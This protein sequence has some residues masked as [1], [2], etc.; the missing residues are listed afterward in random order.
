MTSNHIRFRTIRFFMQNSFRTAS[1][2]A[3]TVSTIHFARGNAHFYFLTP[4][5]T[6]QRN[7]KVHPILR[8]VLV[9]ALWRPSS[10]ERA[11]P[12]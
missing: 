3:R 7:K 9:N 5:Q 4:L 1:R 12:L 2:D 11:F 6:N 8:V 10:L